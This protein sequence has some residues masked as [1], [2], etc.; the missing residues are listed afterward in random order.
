MEAYPALPALPA[1]Q[2]RQPAEAVEGWGTTN[3]GGY[4][5]KGC[6]AWRRPQG[7]VGPCHF[8]AAPERGR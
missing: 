3:F 6:F 2:N 5:S 8:S 4:G 1:R 7:L